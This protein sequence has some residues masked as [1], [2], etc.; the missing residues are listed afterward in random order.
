M[1][2]ATEARL[3]AG[4]LRVLETA[5]NRVLALDPDSPRRLRPLAG[6]SLAVQLTEPP[7]HLWVS[8]TE[9]ELRLAPAGEGDELADATLEASLGGLI[10]LV[11]SRGERSRE[12]VFRGDV[13]VI[14][15]VRRLFGELEVD[16]EE[17]LAAV[18]GD[19]VAHQVGNAARGGRAWGRQTADTLL[20][21]TGEWLTEERRLLP[22]AA[23]ARHFLREVDRLREDTDR[24][25]ARLRRLERLRGEGS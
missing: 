23:E 13:G 21:N 8:F 11:L 18:T 2:D 25:E 3:A 16:L 15:D 10:G 24:L 6:R 1:P 20:R 14:Q 9:A 12:V 5:L 22:P 17:Q 19:V 7:L 4:T